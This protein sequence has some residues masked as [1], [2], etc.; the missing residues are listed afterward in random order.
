[1]RMK[2]MKRMPKM[3]SPELDGRRI[4]VKLANA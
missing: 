3:P 2:R 4:E 1:M